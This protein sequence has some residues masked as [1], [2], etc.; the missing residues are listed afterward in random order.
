MRGFLFP[1]IATQVP[2]IIG[3]SDNV[4]REGRPAA[5][6]A[7]PQSTVTATYKVPT[8]IFLV[9]RD[10]FQSRGSAGRLHVLSL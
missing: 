2:E 5:M 10:S 7:H 9:L 1:H 4:Q 6:Q 8:K 3:S